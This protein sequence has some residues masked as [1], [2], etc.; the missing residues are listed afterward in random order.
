MV[1]FFLRRLSELVGF[2]STL[3]TTMAI[4]LLAD[5]NGNIFTFTYFVVLTSG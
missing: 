2:I 5:N 3:L 4:F 1:H